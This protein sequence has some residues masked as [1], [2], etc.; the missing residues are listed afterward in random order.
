MKAREQV[1]AE[2]G[3]GLEQHKAFILGDG[4]KGTGWMVFDSMQLLSSHN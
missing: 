3:V 1:V 4:K 2:L